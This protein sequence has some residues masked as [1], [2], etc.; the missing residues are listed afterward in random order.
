MYNIPELSMKLKQFDEYEL[1]SYKIQNI[2]NGLFRSIIYKNKKPICFS[3]PKSI[4]F[5][6]FK[7]KY[8]IQ[9]IILDE[10]IDG[11][12][13]NVFYDESWKIAT[14]TVVG[15]KCTFY[16]DKT[17][18]DMFHEANINYDLLDKELCYSFVLQ[19]PENQIV[20][21]IETPTLYLIGCYKIQ[22]NIVIQQ[23]LLT[24]FQTPKQYTFI[25]YDEAITFVQQQSYT[26]KGLML[27]CNN[28]RCKIINDNY[29]TIKLLRGNS[30]NLKYV[31]YTLR[32]TNKLNEYIKYFPTDKFEFYEEELNVLIKQ[33]H[34][35]YIECFI[36]KINTLKT[37]DFPLKHHLYQLHN[38]YLSELRSE[39][40]YVNKKIVSEYIYSMPP[41]ELLSFVQKF[42]L[43]L[44]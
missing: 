3:P 8:D 5:V 1:A 39:K 38:I 40:K 20:V 25:N 33:L 14:R 6:D 31:Y 12:M 4:S 41:A 15:A 7:E 21:P 11:T 26:F 2:E 37:Y 29:E 19:H 10:F 32:K 42:E 16:S 24:T 22:D 27:K 34:T 30:A 17:F 9:N 36:K 35:C 28:D 44:K 18:H 13:I 43:K 23:P